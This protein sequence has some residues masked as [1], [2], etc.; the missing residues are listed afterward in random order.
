MK[1]DKIII[2]AYFG[3]LPNYF[4]IFLESCKNNSDFDFIIISDQ[5]INS[6]SK[7]IKIIPLSFESIKD[8]TKNKLGLKYEIFSPYKLCDYKPA[9]GKIFEEHLNGYTH[10]GHCDADMIFGSISGHISKNDFKNYDKLLDKGHLVFYK[11]NE[12]MNNAFLLNKSS[13]I[14]FDLVTKYKEPC[15]FDEICLPNILKKYNIR[16]YSNTNIADILPQYQ[17]MIIPDIKNIKNQKFYYENGKIFREYIDKKGLKLTDE[18]MYIHLQKR[19]MSISRKLDTSK[20]IYINPNIFT[21]NIETETRINS[22]IYLL[23]YQIKK[24]IKLNMNKIII[25]IM[26][27]NIK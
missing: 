12:T 5:K 7:N 3:K 9:Y 21:N 10:W 16:Q 17:D 1:N 18:Y 25:K 14:G 24:I 11:N 2:L 23:K 4:N 15:Y 19:K 8:I 27:W 20:R 22:K 6:I 13:E 26:I